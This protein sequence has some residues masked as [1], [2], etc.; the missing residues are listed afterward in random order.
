MSFT[1]SLLKHSSSG[2]RSELDSRPRSRIPLARLRSTI[3]TTA[4]VSR[5]TA[6]PKLC[7]RGS[8]DESARAFAFR[9]GRPCPDCGATHPARRSPTPACS[10]LRGLAHLLD[11][12]DRSATSHA[13]PNESS[14]SLRALG[15]PPGIGRHYAG[16]SAPD[17]PPSLPSRTAVFRVSSSMIAMMRSASS[18]AM[19]GKPKEIVALEID[20]VVQRAI[21]SLLEHGHRGRS[22]ALDVRQP[23]VRRLSRRLFR[24]RREERRLAAALQPLAARV[25]VDLPPRELA[26]RA[27]RSGRCARSPATA[28]PRRRPPECVFARRR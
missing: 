5:P 8:F 4:V 16:G 22:D 25:E 14:I 24:Q 20:D 18:G 10:L 13:E 28:D 1:R 26:T 21:A 27:A 17:P 15:D 7:R 3:P 6:A 19:P 2:A 11:A 9:S 12:D 23:H